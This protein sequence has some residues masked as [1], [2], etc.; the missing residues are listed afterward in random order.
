[1]CVCERERVCVCARVRERECVCVCVCARV[2]ERECVCRFTPDFVL[3]NSTVLAVRML[4]VAAVRYIYV[5]F[6][7][8]DFIMTRPRLFA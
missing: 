2:R 4:C 8:I 6:A 7:N 3:Y 5:Y 1:M